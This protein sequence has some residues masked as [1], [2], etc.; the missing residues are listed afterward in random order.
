MTTATTNEQKV[1]AV[2][3]HAAVESRLRYGSG[4]QK[5]GYRVRVQLP[6]GFRST[7]WHWTAEEAWD[8][9]VEWSGVK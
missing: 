1:R 2:Y 9:A 4:E 7:A 3:P 8:E 6:G 5:T